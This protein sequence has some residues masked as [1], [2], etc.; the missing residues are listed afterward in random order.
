MEAG[1]LGETRQDEKGRCDK[2]EK[3]TL[4]ASNQAGN[5][6]DE[7]STLITSNQSRN[8][9]VQQVSPASSIQTI[10]G[11]NQ[12]IS[13]A[14]SSQAIT[15][16]DPQD[17]LGTLKLIIELQGTLDA[18]DQQIKT[19]DISR[20]SCVI[21]SVD[22]KDLPVLLY[23]SC[24]NGLLKLVNI[25]LDHKVDPT[26]ECEKPD[27]YSIL[28]AAK[29]GHH[30]IIDSLLE[31]FKSLGKLKFGLQ[32]RNK[33]G[34]TV[35]HTILK[36]LSKSRNG[37]KSN[38]LNYDNYK[39]SMAV[40]MK[41]KDEFENDLIIKEDYPLIFE[42]SE[43]NLSDFVAIL[44]QQ[45][46]NVNPL[47]Y[48]KT[49]H[50]VNPFLLAC[51]KGNIDTV[52]VLINHIEQNTTNNKE[53]LKDTNGNTAL[54]YILS[55]KYKGKKEKIKKND[56]DVNIT[57]DS[58]NID[59]EDNYF[60]CMELLLSRKDI[61]IDAMNFD[62][63][64]ALHKTAKLHENGKRFVQLLIDKGAR[65][66]IKNKK[67]FIAEVFESIKPTV[68][69]M[70][71]NDEKILNANVYNFNPADNIVE[72][73]SD[74]Q[75]KSN[76][77]EERINLLKVALINGKYIDVKK[78]CDKVIEKKELFSDKVMRIFLDIIVENTIMEK[79]RIK[80]EGPKQKGKHERQEK[81]IETKLKQNHKKCLEILLRTNLN[82]QNYDISSD[83]KLFYKICSNGLTKLADCL[84]NYKTDPCM[85]FEVDEMEFEVD[86]KSPILIASKSGY[87][88]LVELLLSKMKEQG[89][90]K[91]ISGLQVTNKW[92][93][94]AIH[95]VVRSAGKINKNEK[96][97][98]EKEPEINY[99]KCLECLLKYKDYYNINAQ[100]N[101]GNTALHY[102]TQ[103]RGNQQFVK[104]LLMNGSQMTIK[105]NTHVTAS[106]KIVPSVIEGILDSCIMTGMNETF[107]D[108][109]RLTLDL[110]IFS[111][112]C[113]SKTKTETDLVMTL[114]NSKKYKHLL[115]HP[116]ISTFLYIKWQKIRTFCYVNL[117][118]YML[119][120]SCL[121]AYIS[122]KDSY[123]KY[124][125]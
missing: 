120:F 99:Y 52:E 109:L 61:D 79:H 85:E 42:A 74:Q 92:N 38:Q 97:Q 2:E 23:E 91:L 98:E 9:T 33:F 88:E 35:F 108:D 68:D 78:L 58:E 101:K 106:S 54:H 80:V 107:E 125:A 32:Q 55:G 48:F 49:K 70:K 86:E 87:H 65:R 41:Y 40:L 46:S 105:N 115:Y 26:L 53:I 123:N 84:I 95:N 110:S 124:A 63:D 20:F 18:A 3:E 7:H 94:L 89:E 1:D 83:K 96:M 117:F 64:T 22:P 36:G 45:S 77:F 73:I 37:G 31:K 75:V 27:K 29:K 6:E 59:T 30:Q 11:T 25:I 62:G 102:A 100:D 4:I 47:G 82:F 116:V 113:H 103:L 13:Q 34:N 67:G 93:N 119:F 90:E 44:L 28:A 12:Q 71:N 112:N 19:C 15:V 66:D 8:D 118:I 10:Y 43:E 69:I 56:K 57:Y 51:S 114:N 5:S 39:E 17:A 76:D 60:T 24:E 50:K 121:I 81:K 16:I 72:N 21:N 14:S 104:L 122:C 111:H